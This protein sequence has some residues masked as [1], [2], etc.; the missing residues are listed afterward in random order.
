MVQILCKKKMTQPSARSIRRRILSLR[1]ALAFPVGEVITEYLH[2]PKEQLHQSWS[3]ELYP[4][5]WEFPLSAVFGLNCRR[6]SKAWVDLTN[7]DLALANAFCTATNFKP[8]RYPR[9][10]IRDQISGFTFG[11]SSCPEFSGRSYL[12]IFFFNFVSDNDA[13]QLLF[14]MEAN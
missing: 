10:D 11:A 7:A 14:I 9:F 6:S 12:A 3:S 8:C 4:S 2:D 13:D 1:K 5:H